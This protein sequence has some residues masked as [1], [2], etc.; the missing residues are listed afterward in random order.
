M[1]SELSPEA[2][3]NFPK[4]KASNRKLTPVDRCCV[5]LARAQGF[6][7]ANT[8]TINMISSKTAA[9]LSN[10]LPRPLADEDTIGEARVMLRQM[11]AQDTGLDVETDLDVIESILAIACQRLARIIHRHG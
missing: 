7:L 8:A 1:S 2:E 5:R 6:S 9:D 4:I 10:P 3:S 11:I